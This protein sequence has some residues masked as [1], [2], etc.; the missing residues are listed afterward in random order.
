VIANKIAL[1][2]NKD[3]KIKRLTRKKLTKVTFV[4]NLW[5]HSY[6]FQ[7]L[8]KCCNYDTTVLL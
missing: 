5:H 3:H 4:V 1:S 7:S 6:Y 2:K 8:Q